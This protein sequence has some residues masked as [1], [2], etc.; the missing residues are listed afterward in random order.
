[1][2]GQSWMGKGKG[3]GK[4]KGRFAK[5]MTSKLKPEA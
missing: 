3:K 4:G 1:M 2:G 5:E